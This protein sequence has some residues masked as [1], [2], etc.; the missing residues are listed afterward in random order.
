MDVDV[1]SLVVGVVSIV[2][3][4][5]SVG[6]AGVAIFVSLRMHWSSKDVM[7]G[8]SQQ[9]S[10]IKE[11]LTGTQ[12]ELMRTVSTIALQKG[13][14]A[15]IGDTS[16]DSPTEDKMLQGFIQALTVNP[17]LLTK[18]MEIGIAQEE[19]RANRAERR[20]KRP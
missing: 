11:T 15:S 18:V 20:K 8:V 5:V 6:L 13:Q 19:Q 7:S 9:A 10:I 1:F 17:D 4:A 12:E 2:V 16:D 3:G 14:S